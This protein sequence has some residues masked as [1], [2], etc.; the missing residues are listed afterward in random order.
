M[1]YILTPT[2]KNFYTDDSLK[3]I[4]IWNLGG[5]S[6]FPHDY[7]YIQLNDAFNS[8]IENHEHLRMHC[9]LCSGE[10]KTQIKPFQFK[11]YP[12]R[13]FSSEEKF[14]A[15][16]QEFINEPLDIF[17]ELFRCILVAMPGKSGILVCVH[18]ILIDGYSGPLIG[19]FLEYYLENGEPSPLPLQSY[20]KHM[21][22]EIQYLSTVRYQADADYW[23][24]IFSTQPICSIFSEKNSSADYSCQEFRTTV[25]SDLFAKIETSCKDL[26]LYPS[27][28]FYTALATYIQREYRHH[29][30]T[31]G[32]P[33]YNRT[34][35]I[36]A[37]TIGLY[38]HVLP[39]IINLSD[40]SFLFNAKKLER[41]KLKVLR[42]SKMAH[43]SSPALFDVVLNYQPFA[44]DSGSYELGFLYSNALS[45]SLEIHIHN[46]RDGNQRVI[47]RYRTSYF[48]EEEIKELWNRMMNI[49]T[50][51]IIHPDTAVQD[52]PQYS[53]SF[54]ERQE[55]LYKVNDT[56]F[57][58]E[59]SDSETLYSLFE[60][61][62][63]ENQ[64][65]ICLTGDGF[66]Y[67]FEEF[68]SYVQALDSKIYDFTNGCKS[69]IAVLT[70]RSPEM[71]TS[72]YAAIRGGNAYLPI[73][74]DD[75]P[76]RIQFLLKD[77]NAAL[78]LT[79]S[80]FSKLCKNAPAIDVTEFLQA[81]VF[82]ENTAPSLAT[83][84]DTAYIIY[85]SGSTGNP[86]GTKISHHSL[87]NR[88][89]W[90]QDTYPV[91]PNSVILQKTPYTFDVSLWEIFWWGICGCT[92]AASKPGEH[93]LPA[94][95]LESVHKYQITH[96]HF[97]PSVFDLLLTY[98]ENHKEECECFSSVKHL[99]L[100]GETLNASLVHRFY[101]LFSYEN[102]KLHNLYGPTECTIDVTSY[103]CTPNDM[104]PVPIGRPIYNTNVYI[105]DHTMELLPKGMIGELCIGG[106]N[107]GQGYLNNPELTSE[108]FVPNPFAPGMLYRT[109]DYA[110]IRKDGQLV[111]CGRMDG[112]RKLNGQRIELGEIEHVI[113]QMNDVELVV[114]DIRNHNGQDLLAVY[115]CG[116]ASK[117]SV[118]E[119]CQRK[120][121]PYMVPT[122]FFHLDKMPLTS[123]GKLNRHELNELSA[124]LAENNLHD[125]PQNDDESMICAAFCRILQIES[126]GRES[127]FF[128][129]GG[130]SLSMIELLSE[131]P[132]M[133]ITA[134][135]FIKDP[136]P[137][138]LAKCLHHVTA[139]KTS[140]KLSC[141]HEGIIK[142]KALI[143]FPYAGGG[144]VSYAE[145][146]RVSNT[147]APALS[148]YY[149]EYPKDYED[150][151][152]IAKELEILS[153]NYTLYFYSHC[154]GSAAALQIINI[155]EEHDQ[156]IVKHYLAGANIPS[157]VPAKENIW[158]T[159]SNSMLKDIL[160]KA[161][162]SFDGLSEKHIRKMLD[163]YRID[164][165]FYTEYFYRKSDKIHCPFSLVLSKQDLF[166]EKFDEAN[167]IWSRYAD[168]I[169]NIYF[170]DDSSHYFQ[171][172]SAE[173]LMQLLLKITN[174]L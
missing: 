28:L 13:R 163:K 158:R 25:S 69:V 95:T 59:I 112:Q 134:S 155:L 115:Y 85:T 44:E 145:L 91:T 105:L 79:Q 47:I 45:T 165:D 160:Q 124:S 67:T 135:E 24:N 153:K 48:T 117:E 7:N 90:M 154:A 139:A 1:E 84:E 61:T 89:L 171:S 71:Y 68:L 109:G 159:I 129:L 66:S 15:F 4:P 86:K 72:I 10:I 8:M 31:I 101:A 11:Q 157:K 6:L 161:G 3:D 114:A 166:T 40:D 147:I 5:I 98:L 58:Y 17:K 55:L 93:F 18:H 41:E 64:S 82:K 88:I 170:I 167:A 125:L 137:A 121:P 108:K 74:P 30:F 143:V 92:M 97:V 73:S 9:I 172:S 42:H 164:T 122:L 94:K 51:A 23:K 76:E 77:S 50:Y 53:L 16:A 107:V 106:I 27:T 33:V 83:P 127:N 21:E 136:T 100:S 99:F 2:Q 38:M 102:I 29:H 156:N 103:D 140:V 56:F 113:Q 54:E 14:L 52:I 32:M 87:I 130:T 151:V 46:T 35:R 19:A 173:T 60:K 120:L 169:S 119:L 116:N 26:S 70:E 146:T 81:P 65:H 80:K 49:I 131:E 133:E 132:F 57:D 104:N 138:G 141:L 152:Q 118:W 62:A 111:F 148:I 12:Y 144:P 63:L 78:V 126:V 20:E 39:L 128:S 36:E 22:A 37:N 150:C 96:L 142:N 110:R 162:A 174:N 123:S 75:P 168:S 43:N 149:A 34:S